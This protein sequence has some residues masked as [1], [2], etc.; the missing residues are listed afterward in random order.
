VL[1]EGVLS[2]RGEHLQTN[3]WMVLTFRAGVKTF[4]FRREKL[5]TDKIRSQMKQDNPLN[6]SILLSGGKE[7]NKDSP[8]NGE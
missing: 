1:W 8:S 3:V 2:V 5:E 4:G 7:T 6:L